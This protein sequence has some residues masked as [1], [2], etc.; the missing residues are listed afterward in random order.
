MS[1][2]SSEEP[3]ASVDATCEEEAYAPFMARP[4]CKY[5]GHTADLLDISWSK[6]RPSESWM[7]AVLM[8]EADLSALLFTHCN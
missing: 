6:V 1:H 2:H 5:T 7:I 8:V 4:L 3:L